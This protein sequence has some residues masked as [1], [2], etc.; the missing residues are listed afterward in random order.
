MTM[1]T[2]SSS[3]SISLF[4]LALTLAPAGCGPIFTLDTPSG[5][6]ELKDQRSY[7]YRAMTPDGVVLG[8]RVIEDAGKT[9]VA[10]WVQAVTLHMK[11][12]SG[13]ALL[14]SVDVTTASGSA[15]KELRF[16]HD[17][18]GKPYVYVVRI[19]VAPKHQ[20]VIVEAGGA[21]D[22]MERNR[23][24]VEAAMASVKLR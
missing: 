16:G 11:E 10:F 6:I 20:L 17:E 23:P 24:M 19:F 12:L 7:A 13:Y 21:K 15:G 9:D 1:R 18:A 2:L 22:E 5:M 8:V 14:S 3:A 4:A